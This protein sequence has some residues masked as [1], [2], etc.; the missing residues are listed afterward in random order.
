MWKLHEFSYGQ[1]IDPPERTSSVPF[2]Q[3][4]KASLQHR[5]LAAVEINGGA[6]QPARARGHREHDQTA[7]VPDRA[8]ANGIV[9]FAQQL[10]ADLLFGRAGALD[11]RFDAAASAVGLDDAGMDAIH[12][13]PVGLTAVGEAL[14]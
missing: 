7:D 10:F 8:N 4:H 14:V 12:A 3:Q 9:E 6:V 11:F 1:Q 2:T 13:H 5:N